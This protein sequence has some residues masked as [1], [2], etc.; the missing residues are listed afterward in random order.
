MEFGGRRGMSGKGKEVEEA[1]ENLV[2]L[3]ATFA[4]RTRIDMSACGE[5]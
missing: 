2:Q 1:E 5:V 4:P 3:H